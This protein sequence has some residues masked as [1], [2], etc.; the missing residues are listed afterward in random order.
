MS[1]FSP[2]DDAPPA[3]APPPPPSS[4]PSRSSRGRKRGADSDEASQSSKRTRLSSGSGYFL[5]SVKLRVQDMYRGRCLHCTGTPVEVAHVIPRTSTTVFERLRDRNI[6]GLGSIDDADNA[7]PLCG[8]CHANF[9]TASPGLLII[10]T[11]TDLLIEVEK[12]QLAHHRPRVPM[13]AAE[14]ADLCRTDQPDLQYGLYSCYPIVDFAPAPPGQPRHEPGEM[15]WPPREWHGSPSAMVQSA[16]R[17][18]SW[19]GAGPLRIPR[20]VWDD[21]DTLTKLWMLEPGALMSVESVEGR[22]D[23][24]EPALTPSVT[25]PT[26]HL[27]TPPPALP[28]PQ[29]QQRRSFHSAAPDSSHF[30]A[31]PAAH[32]PD[33][34]VLHTSRPT[35]RKRRRSDQSQQM[36]TPNSTPVKRAKH[37]DET[38]D[39][40]PWTWGPTATAQD[41]IQY[42][43][44]VFVHVKEKH[45]SKQVEEDG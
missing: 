38:P 13:S 24:Q 22:L 28:H 40:K 29:P 5:Q 27:S 36:E 41:A 45:T 11:R 39:P 25:P 43:K 18:L 6:I 23:E 19:R 31:T 2:A 7:V 8:S 26:A 17:L 12:R 21:I 33:R 4:T 1:L 44:D 14:Y 32:T 34:E 37:H 42:W 9:D 35:T 10:P 20:Q 30:R 3:M 15:I 16:S